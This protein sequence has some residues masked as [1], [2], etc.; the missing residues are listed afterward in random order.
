MNTPKVSFLGPFG[1]T[2]SH[3]A[4]TYLAHRYNAPEATSSNYI[5]AKEN[6]NILPVLVKNGGYGAIAMETWAECHVPESVSSFG[7]ILRQCPNQETCPF[8]II[9]A[10]EMKIDFTLMCREGAARDKIRKVV[11]HK[12]G[13]GACMKKLASRVLISEEV[14]SNGEAARLVAQDERYADYAALGPISAAAAYNLEIM[15]TSFQDEEAITTFFLLGPKDH[16]V[17]AGKNN[18]ALLAFNLKETGPG[19]AVEPQL[20]LKDYGINMI[21]L[22]SIG[23]GK[24]LNNFVIEIEVGEDHLMIMPK[25]FSKIEKYTVDHLFF[26]PFPVLSA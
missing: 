15:E 22:S 9:G 1:T 5:D 13:R 12:K 24:R 17:V 10:V 26:G 23:Q 16:Q 18:R 3:D 7:N 2:F 20:V 21:Q 11:T 14:R 4:Y 19:A 6:S 8:T 25:V